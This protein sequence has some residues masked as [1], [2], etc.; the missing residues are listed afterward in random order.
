[1]HQI[2]FAAVTYQAIRERLRASEP[3]IDEDTLADTVEGLTD[4][5]EI[6]AALVRGALDDEAMLPRC[7]T[8][9][10]TCR[11]G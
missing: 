4:L 1:M 7:G 10:P 6:V 2:T 11:C 8:G 3:D 9:C 5:H